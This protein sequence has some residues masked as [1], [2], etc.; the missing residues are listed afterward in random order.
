MPDYKGEP[1]E[2]EIKSSADVTE[3]ALSKLN[4]TLKT[5]RSNLEKMI[6]V[7]KSINSLANGLTKLS[8]LNFDKLNNQIEKLDK[9]FETLNNKF[10]TNPLSDF[11]EQS[12][13]ASAS[14][15]KLSNS[16]NKLSKL[17]SIDLRGLYNTLNSLT[18]LSSS[19]F[20]NFNI[21]NIEGLSKS[22]KS[23][24]NFANAMSKLEK[25][26]VNA[27]SVQ[28]SGLKSPIEQMSA[29]MEK[30]D[31]Q[32]T[33]AVANAL[34]ALRSLPSV[35]Q[36]MSALD[37]SKIG[38]VFTTLATQIQPFLARLKEASAELQAFAVI[39]KNINKTSS[40]S[41]FFKENSTQAKSFSAII[42]TAGKSISSMFALNKI[43][44][45][46]NYSKRLADTFVSMV[47]SAVEFNEILNLFNVSFGELTKQARTFAKSVSES[48]NFAEGAILNYMAQFNNL[49]SAIEGLTDEM[50]ATLSEK[51]TIM[52]IDF[53]SLYNVSIESAMNKFQSA[54]S[55]Q[56]RPIR[57]TSGFDITQNTLQSEMELIGI[58]DKSITQ[59]SQLEKRLLIILSL[60]RQMN[61]VGASGDM[62]RTI[63]QTAN[64]LKRMADQVKELGRWIGIVFLQ[65][66]GKWFEYLTAIFI[67]LKEIVKSFALLLGY[68]EPTNDINDLL[69]TDSAVSGLE[70][71]QSGIEK[72]KNATLGIDEL[73][74]VSQNQD[75]GTTDTGIGGI[76]SKILAQI[77]QMQSVF[78][79]MRTQATEIA[80]E[81]L[82]WLGFEWEIDP[83]T[84]ERINLRLKDG[85]TNFDL[86]KGTVT[87]IITLLL[88]AKILSKVIDLFKKLKE[89]KELLDGLKIADKIKDVFSAFKSFSNI[90]TIFTS[91]FSTGTATFLLIAAV[92]AVVIS[93]IINQFDNLKNSIHNIIEGIKIFFDGLSTFV[94]GVISFIVNFFTGRWD[95][96]G[97]SLSVIGDGI[98][99]MFEGIIKAGAGFIEAITS[100]IIGV[101]NTIGH[102]VFSIA[103]FIVDIINGLLGMI[104][105]FINEK[106][107]LLDFVGFGW[108]QP[109]NLWQKPEWK[110]IEFEV[111]KFAN[112]GFP[113]KGVFMYNEGK[114]SEMLGT[115]NGKTAVANNDQIASAI[116]SALI[117][118][119]GEVVNAVQSIS[120]T[121]KVTII[122]V[123]SREIARA[124]TNGQKKLG[125]TVIK[126]GFANA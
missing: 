49:L 1:I 2:L 68:Q 113:Q 95:L 54:L 3:Q 46:L 78:K 36:S 71:V 82:R 42:K 85:L 87:T 106:R 32:T 44:F 125:Q 25:I 60:Y 56:V 120:D 8:N 57:E 47:N 11:S 22:T 39:A 72:V 27:V 104:N 93:A 77:E 6:P 48:W 53:S 112:G 52:A 20:G 29:A 21:S 107:E 23:I 62:E 5:T 118:M 43:Y 102:F 73:N 70:D 98:L 96:L 13:E 123:D 59:M 10:K 55:Q 63:S 114:Y 15:N 16:F 34:R 9:T 51:L 101:I 86:I 97:N 83:E 90:K 75:T 111:P 80:D 91:I 4:I 89:I 94:I 109:F 18:R 38:F 12:K 88:G 116:A 61:N 103:G 117:P 19:T 110:D 99:R 37:L 108:V 40:L 58:R 124:A 100:F 67:V 105:A 31:A 64:V 14:I 115:V 33:S 126:G 41:K 24:N 79:N 50:S 121:D 28:L 76:D 45:F 92:V 7:F 17:E 26:N 84:G 74:I 65:Y 35:M 81:M 122:K 119:F 69:G 30:F 66:F